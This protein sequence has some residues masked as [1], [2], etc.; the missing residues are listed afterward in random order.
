[1]KAIWNGTVLAESDDTVVLEGN[2][3]FPRDALEPEL[4]RESST[5]TTCFWKGIASYLDVVVGG[6]VNKDAAWYYP[7]TS[8]KAQRIR[9]RVAFWHG[10]SVVP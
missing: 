4:F 9:G 3:Y 1:M 6:E 5:H 2:H 8:V 7:D 10:V